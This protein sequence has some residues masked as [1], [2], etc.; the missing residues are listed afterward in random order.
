MVMRYIRLFPL[1]AF[2]IFVLV[3]FLPFMSTGSLFSEMIL[4]VEHCHKYWWTN[5]LYINNFATAVSGEMCIGHSW[6]L[7]NDF[8]FFLYS[9]LIYILLNDKKKV[10]DIIFISTFILSFVAQFF[11]V[12]SYKFKYPVDESTD[13]WSAFYIKPWC[14]GT[15]YII[16]IYFAE[17]YLNIKTEKAASEEPKQSDI[18]WMR[19]L[20][21]FLKGNNIIADIVSFFGIAC[22]VYGIW[23]N[24][25]VVI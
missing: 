1:Y 4:Q 16:G 20:N 7:A 21:Q 15:P 25:I 6:Y 10:R 8:Q 13:Y 18:E 24:H 19:N 22:Y 17:L 5:L 11:T 2:V 12:Y 23:I 9:I 3:N 14:R